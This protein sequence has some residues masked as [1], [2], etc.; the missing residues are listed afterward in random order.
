V[1]SSSCSTAP[2]CVELSSVRWEEAAVAAG[3][4]RLGVSTTADS[5]DS[6]AQIGTPRD[7]QLDNAAHVHGKRDARAG[8]GCMDDRPVCGFGTT[9]GDGEGAV[10]NLWG[11]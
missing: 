10:T 2:K 11:R 3:T 5:L 6:T 7:G 8:L 1:T 9:Q 4:D